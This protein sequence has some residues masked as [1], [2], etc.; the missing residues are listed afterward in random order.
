M[1][2]K[3]YEKLTDYLS[4]SSFICLMTEGKVNNLKM[5][6]QDNESMEI[7]KHNWKKGKQHK[8]VKEWQYE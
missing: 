6:V 4:K 1:K 7:F 3:F 2:K 5:L 8:I